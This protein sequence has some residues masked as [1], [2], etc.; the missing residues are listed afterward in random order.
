ML[1]VCSAAVCGAIV[2][3]A[4]SEAAELNQRIVES[5]SIG[6]KHMTYRLATGQRISGDAPTPA[7]MSAPI[8]SAVETSGYFFGI[9]SCTHT[10]PQWNALALDWGDLTAESFI[11]GFAIGY[12][13][14]APTDPNAV[15][16]EFLFLNNSNGFSENEFDPPAAG[17]VLSLPGLPPDWPYQFA[18]WIVTIE[19]E[20]SGL[21]FCLGD[22]DIDG[23]GLADFGYT[24]RVVDAT[25]ASATGPLLVG[26]TYNP[27]FENAPGAEDAFDYYWQ[28][29]N[30][31]CLDPDG[32]YLYEGTYWGSG[33]IFRQFYLELY[34]Q[35][36][37]CKAP[38]CPQGCGGADL[39]DDGAV[40]LTDLSRLLAAY[41]CGAG[42]PCYD[43]CADLSG[44][45]EIDLADLAQMLSAFGL[46]CR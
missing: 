5:H 34:G 24:N 12:A 30:E 25:G 23:D 28:D 39:D 42:D 2:V 13:T 7:R 4:L 19:L 46:S 14:N 37:G 22:L 27:P 33:T 40:G 26:F 45:G 16:M 29:P 43:E 32:P 10:P 18:G 17:F 15:T 9:G 21:E 11:D 1:R 36:A 35:L 20:G 8:W 6:F 31:P 38:G 3:C 41:G 44:S